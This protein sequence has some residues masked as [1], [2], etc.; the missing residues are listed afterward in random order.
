MASSSIF[1][2]GLLL[3][4]IPASQL[5]PLSIAL[6]V[7][8]S[9]CQAPSVFRDINHRYLIFLLGA[10]LVATPVGVYLL[11]NFSDRDLRYAV[12]GLILISTISVR[13]SKTR[14][15]AITYQ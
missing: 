4:L 12:Y 7:C 1:M 2:A 3:P 10:S 5:V 9:T 8:A 14:S 13:L 15:I 11:S 6:E